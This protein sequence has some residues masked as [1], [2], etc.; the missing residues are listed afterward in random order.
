MSLF[1]ITTKSYFTIFFLHSIH[2]PIKFCYNIIGDRMKKVGKFIA[3]IIT[4]IIGIG[5]FFYNDTISNFILVNFIY[6]REIVVEEANR[7]QK[8]QEVRYVKQTDQ[9]EPKNRNDIMNILYTILNNGWN[10]FTFY[11]DKEYKNC[12]E[13]VSNIIADKS[14]V[15]NLNNFVSPYN[16]Y[17]QLHINYN[18]YGKITVEVDKIYSSEQIRLTELE[19]ERIMKEIIT[20]NMSTEQK[21]KAF[22]DYIINHTIYDSE[23]ADK[24][25]ANQEIDINANSHNAYGLLYNHI[26][27]CGG[28]SD[29]MAIFLDKLG[30]PNIKVSND[31][32]VWNLVFLNNQWL[33]LDLT[34]DDPVTNTHENLLLHNYFLITNQE[35]QT[36]D[37]QYHKFDTTIYPEGQ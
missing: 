31:S 16:S 8:K 20:D 28:Y 32:H 30:I 33:H 14:L 11:C 2:K 21:I 37:S 18:S 4:I 5:L 3:F 9:F 24:L 19:I 34:W 26:S 35:L 13:D 10:S 12:T 23:N 22:H 17:N 27:L 15:S 25:K 29:V 36:K 1:I 7:Y 6:K